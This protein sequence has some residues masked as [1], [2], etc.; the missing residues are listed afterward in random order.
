[1]AN[2]IVKV[3]EEYI[4]DRGLMACPDCDGTGITGTDEEGEPEFCDTCNA[5]GYV[6][7]GAG[8]RQ[9][10]LSPDVVEKW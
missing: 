5:L 7:N 6:G 4:E 9:D 8:E 3:L 1:M 2:L 10:S